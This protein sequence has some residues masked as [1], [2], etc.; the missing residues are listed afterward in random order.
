MLTHTDFESNYKSHWCPGCGNFGILAAMKE[1]LAALDIPPHRILIVSGIGQAAKTP[2]FMKCNFFH[3]LHGRA[4]PLA[5]GAKVANHKLN[6]LVN[7]GDGDCYGEGGNHFIHAIRRNLDVTVL[8]HNNRVY[9]L[10]K[11]QASPTSDT[12]MKTKMQPQGVLSD[13]FNPISVALALGCGFVARGFSGDPSYLSELIQAGMRHKGFSLIDIL[14]PCVSFNHV[15]THQWYKKR[16]KPIPSDHD[17]ADLNAA[18]ALSQ[19]WGD[20]IPVGIFYRKESPSFTER[21]AGLTS[22]IPLVSRA[23]DPAPLSELLDRR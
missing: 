17:V 21:I 16:I 7:T 2:H 10:T 8:A 22:D 12:G 5:T 1:A 3:S 18:F 20:E 6:I 23:Y 14:Q 9:G 11:G 13:P 15:N 4:L 19:I